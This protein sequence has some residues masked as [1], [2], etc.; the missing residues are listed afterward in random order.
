MDFFGISGAN[1]EEDKTST[2]R[3][4]EDEEDYWEDGKSEK[5]TTNPITEEQTTSTSIAPN[6]EEIE[7]SGEEQTL[8]VEQKAEEPAIA[9][10]AKTVEKSIIEDELIVD[11]K[12][13]KL[14]GGN[15]TLKVEEKKLEEPV[16]ETTSAEPKELEASEKVE[17]EPSKKR[18]S[19]MDVLERNMEKL[20]KIVDAVEKMIDPS[21]GLKIVD[22]EAPKGEITS[23]ENKEAKEVGFDSSGEFVAPVFGTYHPRAPHHLKDERDELAMVDEIMLGMMNH[24]LSFNRM[25]LMGVR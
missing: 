23:K 8:P 24:L 7:G 3:P 15:D 10:A 4:G 22:V 12:L 6:T 5:P 19:Y 11:K 13:E 21:E 25:A 14:D 2:P 1:K 18:K 16:V 20:E 17:K 9:L